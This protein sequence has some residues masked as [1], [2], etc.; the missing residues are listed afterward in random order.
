M[1]KIVALLL[2]A[3]QLIAYQA[4]AQIEQVDKEPPVDREV[5]VEIEK[6]KIS[7]SDIWKTYEFNPESVRG[8]R[9][10]NDGLQATPFSVKM[11]GS[12]CPSCASNQP[13]GIVEMNRLAA[14]KKG[15]CLSNNYVNVKTKLTWECQKGH[16]FEATPDSIRK[17]RW[18]KKCK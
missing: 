3:T 6:K 11:R 18:C 5:S 7:L 1:K 4:L 8:L 2:L 17:G 12:W 10:M 14:T 13:L 15:K 16:Q 9:S